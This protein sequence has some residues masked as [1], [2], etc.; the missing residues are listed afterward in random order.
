MRPLETLLTGLLTLSAIALFVEPARRY[1]WAHLAPAAAALVAAVQLLL[2]GYRWQIVPLYCMAVMA[3]LVTA[4]NLRFL[5]ASQDPTGPRRAKW[6]RLLGGVLSLLAVG[7]AAALPVLFPHLRLP[8]PSG[9]YAVGTTNLHFIDENRAETFT[10]DARDRRELFARVWYPAEVPV[11]KTPVAYC[12]NAREISRALTGPTRLPPFLFDH[13]AL[14]KTSSYRDAEIVEG[15]E[16]FPVVIFSHAYWGSV[17][18]C[19]ALMEELASQG[20]VAVSLGHSYETPYLIQ[21]DGHTRAFDPRNEEFCLR[22]VERRRAFAVEQQLT[23]TRNLDELDALIREITRLRPKAVESV[24]IWAEDV[25]SMI[26][27][28]EKLNLGNGTF[29]QRLDL[30]RIA[31]LGH[32]CGGAAAGQACLD[33][34]RCKAG[35]NIDG[36]Q[37]G[38]ILDEDLSRPF[39]FIHHDNLHALNKTPNLVFFEKAQAPAYLLTIEGTGHLSF[40]D[41]SFYGRGSVFRLMSPVGEIDGKRCHEIVC[42]YV[43]AFLD[44]HLRGRDNDLLDGTCSRHPEVEILAPAPDG[45]K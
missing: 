19:T 15:K 39:M 25:S 22:G 9:P 40:S 42:D 20:Y 28:L 34:E 14:A 27:E 3:L 16:R 30:E 1:R 37:L 18:Q 7:L 45:E 10:P 29:A 12:E 26:D 2:E 11:G 17:S 6:A 41:V 8:K 31:V 13:L 35:I 36:L 44:K 5:N 23:Q 24:H 21:T 38:D 43:L 32:S 4:P 33:D